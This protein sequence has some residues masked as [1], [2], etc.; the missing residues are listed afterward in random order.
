MRLHAA[1]LCKKF[2]PVPTTWPVAFIVVIA[3]YSNTMVPSNRFCS[4]Y[5]TILKRT[6][7]KIEVWHQVFPLNPS[8]AKEWVWVLM[9]SP[10]QGKE[11]IHHWLLGELAFPTP[12]WCLGLS[13]NLIMKG[14]F[15]DER[16][17][18]WLQVD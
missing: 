18:A 16:M 4:P 1:L 2:R 5:G 17:A 8:G 9:Q 3:A 13:W 10:G 7:C 12:S 14:N 6:R 11:Q 15:W